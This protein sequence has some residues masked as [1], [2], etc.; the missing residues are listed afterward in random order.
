MK[1]IKAQINYT[2]RRYGQ[3]KGFEVKETA[4]PAHEVVI[5]SG[6]LAREYWLDF[7]RFRQLFLFLAWRDIL[8]RYKQTFF[9]V[10]WAIARPVLSVLIFTFLFN[11]IA[12]LSSGGVPYPVFVLA[13]ML[14]WQFF[15]TSL[16]DA[17]NS[18]VNNANMVSKVYFPRMLVPASA[19]LVN[20]V[21]LLVGLA[22]LA[23]LMAWYR[24]GLDP[25]FVAFPAILALGVALC[26]GAGLWASALN[27][28]Y[29]DVKHLLPFVVQL[30]M[31]V[32][33]VGY[34]SQ[35]VPA[36]WQGWYLINPMVGVIEG[37]RWAFFGIQ[38]TLLPEALAWSCAWTFLM[39]AS[40]IWYFRRTER[41][42]ADVI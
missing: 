39:L 1:S 26:L 42:F 2:F 4:Q 36:A 6:R 3:W 32:S 20:L 7:W 33:P 15:S 11:K 31:Y 19:M 29:R 8:V 41:V 40:G 10:A 38:W 34:S 28:K 5:E 13:A 27:V 18:L 17:G 24:V 16:A 35:T 12:K 30:G 22:V 23:V 14:P 21:D 9:G 37:I 25:R